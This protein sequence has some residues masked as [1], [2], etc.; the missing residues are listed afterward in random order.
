MARQI[1]VVGAVIVS[2]GRVLCAQRGPHGANAGLW[3]FPGGKIEPHESARDALEREIAEE[4]R[5]AVEVGA[6]IT[7][8]SHEYDFGVVALT[9]FF[10]RLVEGMPDPAEHARIQWL[11]P[12]ELDTLAWAPADVPAVARIRA[13]LAT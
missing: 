4:L 10:C 9:T 8:S 3:E 1:D 11:A 7:N 5:C 12:A 2:D 13:L 6:E